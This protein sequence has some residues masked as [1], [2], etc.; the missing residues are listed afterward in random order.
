[1]TNIWTCKIGENVGE[2]PDGADSPMRDAVIEAYRK[3]W[4]REPEFVFS[5]WGGA[6]TQGERD[7]VNSYPEAVETYAPNGA[8]G[9]ESEERFVPVE[10][11]QAMIEEKDRQIEYLQQRLVRSAI[12]DQQR[13]DLLAQA[14]QRL[15]ELV[16]LLQGPSPLSVLLSARSE[17]VRR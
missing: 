4:G 3:L 17:V 6:L 11:V 13:E 5:G 15:Y 10:S 16:E 12:R 1:M 14:T 2:L 7:C 8:E 9:F